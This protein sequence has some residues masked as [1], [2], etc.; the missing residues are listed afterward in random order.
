MNRTAPDRLDM[1][2]TLPGPDATDALGR[3]LAG[4]LRAGDTLLLSGPIGAGKSHLARAIILAMMDRT[5]T[6]REDVPS[7]TYTLVQTYELDGVEVWHADLYR[8]SGPDEIWEL[9]LDAAFDS[10]ICLVEWPDRLAQAAPEAALRIDLAAD[11]ETDGRMARLTATSPRW[12][13]L[14]NDLS[15]TGAPT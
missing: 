8:L 11:P 2:L 9:G 5:G 12:D 4:G 10:A 3:A 15:A 6:P 13:A 14:R 7:P 1:R